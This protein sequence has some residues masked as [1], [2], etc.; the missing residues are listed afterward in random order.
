MDNLRTIYTSNIPIDCH[1]IK[2][3]L[4]AEGI[5]CFIYDENLVWG[6]PFRAVAIGGVKLKVTSNN[7]KEATTILTLLEQNKLS[8][9][10]GGY[11]LTT[12]FEENFK[13]QDTILELKLQIRKNPELLLNPETLT[14]N[15]LSNEVLSHII[16]EET[17]FLRLKELK[18]N[19][20]F[21][22]FFYELF[23]FDRS[24][25]DYLRLRPVDYYIELDLVKYRTNGS[26]KNEITC[27]N[28]GSLNVSYGNAIDYKW[29]ILYLLL[30]TLF[31]A[32]FPLI[33][34]NFHCFECKNN[35]KKL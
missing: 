13:I 20:T 25:F 19:L 29:D 26:Y 7:Y 11:N 18:L 32:P 24:V 30:S 15:K 27:P 4:E 8:D 35:F 22:Q 28:C 33:R 5:K 1:I 14:S 3:R 12:V 10:K 23:D 16:K 31:H 9:S 6:H 34:K 17:E 2:G 21:K